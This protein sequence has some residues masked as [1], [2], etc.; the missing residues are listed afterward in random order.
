MGSPQLLPAW[1]GSTCSAK[2]ASAPV[3]CLHISFRCH[4]ARELLPGLRILPARGVA[5]YGA[6]T[7]PLASFNPAH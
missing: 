3:R 1:P 6:L 4:R 2:K 5:S 7:T